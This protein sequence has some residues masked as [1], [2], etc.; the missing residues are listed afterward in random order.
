MARLF[1]PRLVMLLALAF[2]V[3]GW[4]RQPLTANQQAL[5]AHYTNNDPNWA[6]LREAVVSEDRAKGILSAAF[7]RDLTALEGHTFQI[8]GFMT[9]LEVTE[10][11]AHF[12]LTRRSTTC[13][14]CPP[15]EPTEAVEVK[16]SQPTAFTN[17]EVAVSGRLRLVA[18][19]DQGLFYRLEISSVLALNQTAKS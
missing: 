13:P 4:S 17:E 9:P 1:I 7:P 8:S 10:R 3:C 19:S 11:T 5:L 2:G 6:I 14:F 16:L 12:I 18:S 15:N